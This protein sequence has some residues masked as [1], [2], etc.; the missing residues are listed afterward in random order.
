MIAKGTLV[1]LREWEVEDGP[2]FLEFHTD[3]Q[4]WKDLNGP[5]Y[6]K[7]TVEEVRGM[8]PRMADCKDGIPEALVIEEVETGEFIGL[9]NWY[10]VSKETNWPAVG[11]VIYDERKW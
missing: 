4:R 9:V 10:W 2:R 1:S 5:Y 6:P 7:L 8:L 3:H 11:I